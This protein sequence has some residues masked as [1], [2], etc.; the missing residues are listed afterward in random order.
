MYAANDSLTLDIKL[1]TTDPIGQPASLPI[2][3]IYPVEIH[4]TLNRHDMA[5]DVN[6]PYLQ[7]KNRLLENTSLHIDISADSCSSPRG[8]LAIATAFPT[9][10]GTATISLDAH[11]ITNSID[12]RIGW[13]IDREA[14]FSGE[15]SFNTLLG[16]PDDEHTSSAKVSRQPLTADININPGHVTINDT[17]W[18]I[19]IAKIGIAPAATP[20]KA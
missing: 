14:D 4:G 8:T 1:K 17:I 5:L 3:V 12:S 16:H 6:A 2:A 20:S 9:K 15:V 10:K 18:N 19:G 7:Q 11:A 13:R